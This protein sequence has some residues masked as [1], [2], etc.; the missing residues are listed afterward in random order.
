MLACHLKL[1]IDAIN[2]N[3]SEGVENL[4]YDWTMS[5]SL[6]L[7]NKKF[8]FKYFYIIDILV[9]HLFLKLFDQLV[10]MSVI[11]C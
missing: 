5:S 11:A 6:F 4:F 8:Y 3:A 1:P 9:L 7:F 2:V 10:V